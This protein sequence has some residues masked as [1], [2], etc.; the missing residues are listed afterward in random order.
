MSSVNCSV[1]T[2]L[3]SA[4][5]VVLNGSKKFGWRSD[6]LAFPESVF[7]IIP[8]KNSINADLPNRSFPLIS[9]NLQYL[10]RNEQQYIK[11]MVNIL[12]Q[13]SFHHR[14]ERS[15]QDILISNVIKDKVFFFFISSEPSDRKG[16]ECFKPPKFLII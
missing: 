14:G 8:L 15:A 5:F 11:S 4:V 3:T 12:A 6:E 9:R 1:P 2:N 13:F 7:L 10:P 16:H